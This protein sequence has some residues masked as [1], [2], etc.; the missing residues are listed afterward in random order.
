MDESRSSFSQPGL[1]E[2]L[3]TNAQ[4]WASVRSRRRAKDAEAYTPKPDN[5]NQGGTIDDI[6]TGIVDAT[7]GAF[8]ETPQRA[9]DILESISPNVVDQDW[10]NGGLHEELEQGLVTFLERA[11]IVSSLNK[12]GELGTDGKFSERIVDGPDGMAG[13]FAKELTRAGISMIGV[14]KVFSLSKGFSA[15]ANNH[16]FIAAATTSFVGDF[17][18]V[19]PYEERAA[20]I[21]KEF[22]LTEE[23]GH[24]LGTDVSDSSFEAALK[25]AFE[26]AALGET[27]TL[28]GHAFAKSGVQKTVGN[29][30]RSVRSKNKFIENQWFASAGE[31][32]SDVE[33]DT[34][35]EQAVQVQ[36]ARQAMDTLRAGEEI[37]T[38]Y[39]GGAPGENDGLAEVFNYLKAGRQGELSDSGKEILEALEYKHSAPSGA[40][41][42]EKAAKDLDNAIMAEAK[43]LLDM[44]PQEQMHRLGKEIGLEMDGLL[45][46]KNPTSKFSELMSQAREKLQKAE[47]IFIDTVTSEPFLR[48]PGKMQAQFLQFMDAPVNKTGAFAA[49]HMANQEALASRLMEVAEAAAGKAG[50]KGEKL[51]ENMS[52]HEDPR[53]MLKE[54]SRFV[55]E[56]STKVDPKR[57]TATLA[58]L[59]PATIQGTSFKVSFSDAK[60]LADNILNKG[61]SPGQALAN[62]AG[63]LFKGQVAQGN[64][65]AV[66][67]A[68]SPEEA[69]RQL[70]GL[71]DFFFK[72]M[73][74]KLPQNVED[75]EAQAK[76][77]LGK[78]GAEETY[79]NMKRMQGVE[80]LKRGD[81]EDTLTLHQK[82]AAQAIASRSILLAAVENFQN[83][84]LN[85]SAM[86]NLRSRAEVANAARWVQEAKAM[87]DGLGAS[88]GRGLR[89]RQVNPDLDPR[90]LMRQM[91]A[92]YGDSDK[93]IQQL[94]MAFDA[95]DIANVMKGNDGWYNHWVGGLL[96]NPVT[97]VVNATS[98]LV[99]IG[100]RPLER[101]L[102][103]AYR[104]DLGDMTDNLKMLM[105]I[106]GTFRGALRAGRL[107]AREGVSSF[108]G[109]EF[110]AGVAKRASGVGNMAYNRLAATGNRKDTGY[111]ILKSLEY[112]LDI[113]GKVLVGTDEMLKMMNYSMELQYQARK[114]TKELHP[115]LAGSDY[116]ARVGKIAEELVDPSKIKATSEANSLYKYMAEEANMKAQD[117][118]ASQ[119]WTQDISGTSHFADLL[120]FTQKNAAGRWVL[121]F[122]QTPMNLMRDTMAHLPGFDLLVKAER[123]KYGRLLA[124]DGSVLPEKAAQLT[125][126]MGAFS[127][128]MEGVEEGYITGNG[129]LEPGQRAVWLT[130]YQPNSVRIGDTWY[131][132]DR[133][134]PWGGWIGLM[135]DYG[136]MANDMDYQTNSSVSTSMMEALMNR[137]SDMSFTK[138]IF[139]FLNAIDDPDNLGR[140]M[141]AQ[142]GTLVPLSSAMRSAR[143]IVDPTLRDVRGVDSDGDRNYWL[144]A[145]NEL[146]N[147][148]PGFSS[149]LP[150]RTNI[151]GEPLQK[152]SAYGF[153]VVNPFQAAEVDTDP[154][155][156]LL[157]SL[158]I[159]FD[160]RSMQR[161]G[162]GNN[163]TAQQTYE[164]V[165]EMNRGG[166]LKERLYSLM[167]SPSFLAKPD[168]E[169]QQIIQKILSKEKRKALQKLYRKPEWYTLKTRDQIVKLETRGGGTAYSKSRIAA[170]RDSLES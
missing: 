46:P 31:R 107:A 16:K 92:T 168:E 140:Y 15:F 167:D 60:E 11:P 70:E 97:W 120:K 170:L 20:D 19:D 136:E 84:K 75:W 65:A 135:A 141:A 57:G 36:T 63:N 25:S 124:G 169:K 139:E 114:I 96:S 143:G 48:M 49:E 166:R 37:Y 33:F 145:V 121:P 58:D 130:H 82:L 51:L 155:S 68:G 105:A 103:A 28:A 157:A 38:A 110:Q 118:A 133:I 67:D 85:A 104:G 152:L 43:Q 80:P 144:Q 13:Q 128:V 122:A 17:A 2:E 66:F 161:T 71:G 119:T 40:E 162:Q 113:P 147:T 131:R 44:T 34:I 3:D 99:N 149:S 62:A 10:V 156:K 83:V 35:K 1:E 142:A 22:E 32:I 165:Q 150:P 91:V 100:Y 42:A 41:T 89:A 94:G 39:H 45:D 56:L 55:R 52:R 160:L 98:G 74:I 73:D 6:I 154:R 101:S 29:F 164:W 8:T 47:Q 138:G 146:K 64:F 23:L 134:L 69:L 4:S 102:A 153:D 9:V 163:L 59:T 7:A 14:G 90:Q 112:A 148:I 132:Y 86:T 79:E 27:L 53:K 26:G 159:S 111:R 21:L 61:M 18:T 5:E 117:Y 106:P 95:K 109:T 24:T 88:L 151:F 115:E 126:G 50:E 77:M 12:I 116:T 93:L 54:M 108:G 78:L 81:T 123:E 76:D 87:D 125:M 30:L 129:P 72:K 137:M 127:T 158:S